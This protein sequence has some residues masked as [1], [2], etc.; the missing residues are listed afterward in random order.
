MKGNC[1]KYLLL[2]EGSQ[3]AQK[4]WQFK[5][6]I[7]S[8]IMN[9]HVKKIKINRTG[10]FFKHRAKRGEESLQNKNNRNEE[11]K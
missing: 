9:K 1:E 6:Q 3:Y 2:K 11:I 5:Q 8:K 4:K 7:N 10:I